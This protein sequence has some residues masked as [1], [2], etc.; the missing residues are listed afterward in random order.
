M[1]PANVAARNQP[2][3]QKS[4]LRPEINPGARNQSWGKAINSPSP[5][6]SHDSISDPPAQGF[7]LLENSQSAGGSNKQSIVALSQSM[8]VV[9]C[10]CLRKCLSS[11][12]IGLKMNFEAI[13]KNSFEDGIQR[14]LGLTI[15]EKVDR[16][17]AKFKRIP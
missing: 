15:M 1:S 5:E 12:S 11:N 8:S 17:S 6:I 14:L 10:Y 16:H 4:T 2:C 13:S 7:I 9:V 3:G